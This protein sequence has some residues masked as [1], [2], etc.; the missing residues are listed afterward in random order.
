MVD[1]A[2]QA[3]LNFGF[4]VASAGDVNGDG[5]SDVIVGLRF[6]MMGPNGE[7]ALLYHGSARINPTAR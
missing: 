1:D 4:S 2:D 6:M 3:V 5:Y 7:G